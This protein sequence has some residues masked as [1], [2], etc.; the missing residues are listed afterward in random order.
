VGLQFTA[1]AV[2][3][4]EELHRRGLLTSAPTGLTGP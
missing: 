4:L 1:E 3:A 2:E